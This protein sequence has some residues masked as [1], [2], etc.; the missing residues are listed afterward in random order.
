[1]STPPRS[2]PSL[3]TAWLCAVAGLGCPGAQVKPPAPENCSKD[4]LAAMFQE[5]NLST[6]RYLRAIVDIRQEYDDLSYEPNMGIYQE[7]PVIGR[8]LDGYGNVPRGTLLYGRLWMGPGIYN[9]D[10]WTGE[11]FLNEPA[12]LGR[13]TQAELPDGRKYPVC[14]VLG[15]RDGRIAKMEGSPPGAAVL[16]RTAPM[17]VVIRWP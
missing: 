3:L 4:A 2:A 12:V 9:Q 7:G 5:L 10:P 16:N 13:Y 8:V 15:D 6:N 14:I 17:S 1:M 11:V